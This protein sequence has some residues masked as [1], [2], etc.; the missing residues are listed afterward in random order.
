MWQ[1]YVL[2]WVFCELPA[3]PKFPESRKF[4]FKINFID[5]FQFI[6][7]KEL[8]VISSLQILAF[9]TTK[10]QHALV[11]EFPMIL[12]NKV[13]ILQS[14]HT[15]KILFLSTYCDIMDIFQIL[16]WHL[17]EPPESKYQISF[18]AFWNL[19]L[20]KWNSALLI[21]SQLFIISIEH[22]EHYYLWYWK[23]CYCNYMQ[24]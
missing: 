7:R 6:L 11:L 5:V 4:K 22:Q 2:P 24:E 10:T 16:C 23:P 3:W 20:P 12:F 14:R 18:H 1:F 17:Y 15:T 8:C 13:Y 21:F 9:E 19:R